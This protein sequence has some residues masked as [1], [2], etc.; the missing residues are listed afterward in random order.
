L[1]IHI[2][3][4]RTLKYGLAIAQQLRFPLQLDW[5]TP[6]PLTRLSH[7]ILG[8]FKEFMGGAEVWAGNTSVLTQLVCTLATP[9][10]A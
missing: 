7:Y 5:R 2:Y 8:F 10:I 9:V 3:I 6:L 4:Y 1:I